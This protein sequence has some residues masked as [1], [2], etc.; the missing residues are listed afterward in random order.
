MDYWDHRR[1]YRR[2]YRDYWDYR[3]Y[4]DYRYYIQAIEREISNITAESN[5]LKLF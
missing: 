5:Q 3:D 2:D 4:I 1:D